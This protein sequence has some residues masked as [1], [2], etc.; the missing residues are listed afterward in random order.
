MPHLLD[1]Y[2]WGHRVNLLGVAPPP[3]PRMK[4]SASRLAELISATLDNELLA[5]RA[6]ELAERLRTGDPLERAVD[7]ILASSGS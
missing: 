1:Q 7:A 3:L 4:L 5:D 6:R 2:Y